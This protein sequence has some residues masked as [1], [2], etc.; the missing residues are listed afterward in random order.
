MS[1]PLTV[2]ITGASSG[3]GAALAQHYGQAG[4]RLGLVGR[5]IDALQTTAQGLDGR[6]YVADVRDL[7]ATVRELRDGPTGRAS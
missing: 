4:A 2:F 1:P 3:L 5:R 7:A 6:C